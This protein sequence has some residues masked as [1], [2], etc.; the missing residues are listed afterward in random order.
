MPERDVYPCQCPSCT[1]PRPHPDQE[2]HRQMNRLMSRL[3]EQQRRWYAAVESTKVG[4]GGDRL[5]S[6]RLSGNHG[7]S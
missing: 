3:D 7:F 5:L 1:G 6:Q 2:I 4:H